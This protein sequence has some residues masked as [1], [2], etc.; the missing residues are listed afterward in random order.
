M[1]SGERLDQPENCPEE[2]FELMQSCWKLDPDDRPSFQ[3]LADSI[4]S[5]INGLCQ[6][7]DLANAS[8]IAL[9]YGSTT[10]MTVYN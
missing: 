5:C 3:E 4:Q 7:S 8:M 10:E 2:V 1:T 9:P 6:E